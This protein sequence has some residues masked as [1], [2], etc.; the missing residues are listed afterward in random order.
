MKIP[1]RSLAIIIGTAIAVSKTQGGGGGGG[2]NYYINI[3]S[4]SVTHN[5]TAGTT[6]VKI[7]SNVDWEVSAAAS[8]ITVEPNSGSGNGTIEITFEEYESEVED[9]VTT[10]TI[11][12]DN[13]KVDDVILTVKQK[14]VEEDP[15]VDPDDETIFTDEDWTKIAE[16]MEF[17]LEKFEEIT[18]LT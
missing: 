18:P 2:S 13:E 11:S 5:Y 1:A 10:I 15:D 17:L 7:L 12:S 9:R 4:S 3:L 16:I 6:K 8:W 14:K